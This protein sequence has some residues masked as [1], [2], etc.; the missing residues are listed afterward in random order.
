MSKKEA[1]E[2][3]RK[4]EG[5]IQPPKKWFQSVSGSNNIGKEMVPTKMD[6][7]QKNLPFLEQTPTT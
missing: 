1:S 5:L 7:S 6:V 4:P 2:A 3:F